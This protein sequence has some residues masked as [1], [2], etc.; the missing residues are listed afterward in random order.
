MIH[1]GLKWVIREFC[2]LLGASVLFVVPIT[3]L[4]AEVGRSINLAYTAPSPGAYTGYWVALE[5]K[6]FEKYGLV[7]GK[8]VYI[9]GA[10]VA[11]ASL[12]SGEIDVVL[13]QAAAPMNVR[14]QGGDATIFGATTNILPYYIFLRKGLQSV[15]EMEGKR[16]AVSRMG[17]GSHAGLV[18]FFR[19]YGVDPEK[20]T[21]VAA[22]DLA[23]RVGSFLTGSV[24]LIGLSPPYQL[25]LLDQGYRVYKNLL[26]ERVPWAQVIIAAR[27]SWLDN[28]QDLARAFLSAIAEGGY[29][30]PSHKDEA[31]R[32][33]KKYVPSSDPRAV[34]ESWIYFRKAFVPNLRPDVAGIR[35]VRDF[36]ATPGNTKIAAIAPEDYV[37]WRALDDLERAKF[38]AKLASRY[39]VTLPVQ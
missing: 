28:N 4:S 30:G 38:F 13:L 11:M 14:A 36:S 3:A 7:P 5:K 33:W 18:A 1:L 34:E 15:K 35:N 17:A 9:S 32:I 6:F 31:A 12:L 10:T 26:D 27:R 39:G 20:V 16:A 22:G 25:P 23:S 2:A 29:Y 8:V 19:Q 21:F 24:D 37:H